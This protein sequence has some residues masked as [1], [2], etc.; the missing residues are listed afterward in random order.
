MRAFVFG[1][2]LVATAATAAHGTT[3]NSATVVRG[4][5]NVVYEVRPTP[6]PGAMSRPDDVCGATYALAGASPTAAPFARGFLLPSEDRSG[7]RPAAGAAGDFCTAL[8]VAPTQGALA[9]DFAVRT[10]RELQSELTLTGFDPALRL[11]QNDFVEV[12]ICL[13]TCAGP[14]ALIYRITPDKSVFVRAGSEY[15]PW[16]NATYSSLPTPTPKPAPA[17]ISTPTS[18]RSAPPLWTAELAVPWSALPLPKSNGGTTTL[19]FTMCVHL[20]DDTGAC[21]PPRA[22]TIDVAL[23]DA[24]RPSDRG[25]VWGP[26]SSLQFLDADRRAAAIAQYY[27]YT[28]PALAAPATQKVFLDIPPFIGNAVFALPT[29]TASPAHSSTKLA[30]PW[31]EINAPLSQRFAIAGTVAQSGPLQSIQNIVAEALPSPNPLPSGC[32]SCANFQSAVASWFAIPATSSRLTAVPATAGADDDPFTFKNLPSLIGGAAFAYSD[33]GSQLAIAHA[34]ADTGDSIATT[35]TVVAYDYQQRSTRVDILAAYAKRPSTPPPAPTATAIPGVIALPHLATYA[36]SVGHDFFF[37]PFKSGTITRVSPYARLLHDAT[38]QK[39][40][41]LGGVE[42]N[43]QS[44]TAAGVYSSTLV[45]GYRSAERGYV[46]IGG[47]PVTSPTVYGPFGAADLSFTPRGA[48][49]PTYDLTIGGN[50]YYSFDDRTRSGSAKLTVSKSVGAVTLG[51]FYS[52]SGTRQTGTLAAVSALGAQLGDDPFQAVIDLMDPRLRRNEL[53]AHDYTVGLTV[54]PTSLVRLSVGYD[55]DSL[56]PFCETGSNTQPFLPGATPVTT[57][58]VACGPGIR[59]RFITGT[60]SITSGQFTLAGAIKPTYEIGGRVS[61]PNNR[62]Y[63]ALFAWQIDKCSSLT[64]TT[65]N[66]SG[67][68]SSSTVGQLGSGVQA[69]LT[70]EL[71]SH[72]LGLTNP[73]TVVVGITNVFGFAE[74]PYT[75]GISPVAPQFSVA[76]PYA[77]HTRTFYSGLR[78]GNPAFRRVAGVDDACLPARQPNPDFHDG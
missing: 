19:T 77:T 13:I 3:A 70:S 31:A 65:T 43:H 41:Y 73:P 5:G 55:F 53:E 7:R 62:L 48:D 36:F 45:G 16:M 49:L 66:D 72:F 20:K 69:E 57:T 11:D 54:S 76:L 59:Q 1:G 78:L 50:S 14:P 52:V 35:S 15:A 27:V 67:A 60:A 75:G 61:S 39:N 40:V 23:R 63:K 64:V 74:T 71:R 21:S 51:A 37:G 25:M 47:T 17:G 12:T 6:K 22:G 10:S 18:G 38:N 58:L 24:F 4:F 9:F 8:S 29:P 30:P 33:G 34:Q 56:A 26:S 28:T 2:I 68:L 42:M 46:Q 32:A 44:A